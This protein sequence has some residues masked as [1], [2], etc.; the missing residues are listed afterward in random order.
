MND[1]SAIR[2]MARPAAA[3][4]IALAAG[5]AAAAPEPWVGYLDEARGVSDDDAPQVLLGATAEAPPAEPA[6]FDPAGAWAV[7]FE[8]GALWRCTSNTFLNYTVLP[9]VLSIRTPAHLRFDLGRAGELTLRSRISLLVEP[10][11]VGPESLYLGVSGSPSIEWWTPS[12][13]LCAYFSIGG[14]V[15]AIDSRGVPGG[16]GQDLTYNWFIAAGVRFYLRDAFA[17]S[18]GGMFQHFSDRGATDPNPGL[19]QLGP[20]IGLTWHF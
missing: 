9:Q 6:P 13:R 2:A 8:T 7:D 4:V 19:D 14:G 10:I 5:S 12:R 11:V 16:Q 1:P 3:L 15:G 18:V 17:V 20:T